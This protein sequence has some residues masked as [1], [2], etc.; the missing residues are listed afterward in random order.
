MRNCVRA[1]TRCK[2]GL[3]STSRWPWF[4]LGHTGDCALAGRERA[5]R[6]SSASSWRCCTSSTWRKL[7][8]CLA[9]QLVRLRRLPPN[10]GLLFSCFLLC[11]LLS[12][13]LPHSAPPVAQSCS[14]AH[15]LLGS[16]HAGSST[17]TGPGWLLSYHQPQLRA[18]AG[19]AG[20]CCMG[21]QPSN[22]CQTASVSSGSSLCISA[23]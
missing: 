5:R 9:L 10:Q 23:E 22:H 20:G 15:R 12:V 17:G 14:H 18:R 2:P 11:K 3:Y 6:L 16:Q 13:V 21:W 7:L 1:W 8:R 4:A 19:P